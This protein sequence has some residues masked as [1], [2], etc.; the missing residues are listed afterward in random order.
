MYAW[1]FVNIVTLRWILAV[2]ELL[3]DKGMAIKLGS[4]GLPLS[5][6]HNHDD[7]VIQVNVYPVIELNSS[8]DS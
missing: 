7:N 3:S 6:G 8:N 5:D 4:V 1:V 2:A